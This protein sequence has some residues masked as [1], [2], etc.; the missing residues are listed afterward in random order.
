MD[1]SNPWSERKERDKRKEKKKKSRDVK[2][3][4]KSH[5]VDGGNTR[6]IFS[7]GPAQVKKRLEY[8]ARVP[9]TKG[10]LKT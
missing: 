6:N 8:G 10:L 1:P 7:V 9:S 3:R 5:A 4:S 2:I